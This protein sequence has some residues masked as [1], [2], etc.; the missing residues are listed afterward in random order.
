MIKTIGLVIRADNA[1]ATATAQRVVE[2]A[3]SKGLNWVVSARE[4]VP[5]GFVA[6]HSVELSELSAH[7]DLV[8]VIGGD[9]SMLGAARALAKADTPVLG[10]NRGSLGFLT[11]IRPEDAIQALDQ[12]LAGD[13][14][15]DRRNLIGVVVER[16]GER[17]ASGSALNDIVL[18]KGN[19]ARMLSFD[20]AVGGQKVYDAKAD[21]LIVATPTGS[22]AYSL[23][24]GGPILHPSLSA[25]VV[26]PMFPHTMADRPLVIGDDQILCLSI[27]DQHQSLPLIS[28][29]GQTHIS[30]MPGDRIMIRKLK[31]QLH[32][33]HPGKDYNYYAVCREKLGWATRLGD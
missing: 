12:A 32:L 4:G 1:S 17:I 2:H 19:S 26:V 31:E 15:I 16:D 28:C 9:G 7:C 30:V 13:C 3:Q 20:V 14:L 21:G 27:T 10:V 22:T 5:D 8:M 24:A 11:D 29:D 25:W 18:H 33:L 6:A 23:S